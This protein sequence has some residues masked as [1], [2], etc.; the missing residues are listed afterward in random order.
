LAPDGSVYITGVSSPLNLADAFLSK[1]DPAGNVAWT[2]TFGTAQDDVAVGVAVGPQGDVLVAGYTG[3]NLGGTFQGGFFDSFFA[4]FD[5][6]G[7]LQAISQFGTS[8][9]DTG[10]GLTID[11]SA[12]LYLVGRTEGNLAGINQ[13]AGDIFITKYR[14]V[15]EPATGE[16]VEVLAILLL[17]TNCFVFRRDQDAADRGL[18]VG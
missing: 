14:L 1:I 16:L 3:G 5:A 15:P 10:A 6:N 2:K 18:Q 12:N 7:T 9:V 11:N 8:S 17:T 13:G 4:Q